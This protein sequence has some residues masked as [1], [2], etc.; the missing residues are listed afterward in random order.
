M[1]PCRRRDL[2]R[3]D[4]ARRGGRSHLWSSP[5][6]PVELVEPGRAA[7]GEPACRRRLEVLR[8]TRGA[9]RTRWRCGRRA[10]GAGAG[11]ARRRGPRRCRGRGAGGRPAASRV[12]RR[13]GRGADPRSASSRRGRGRR[14]GSR[15]D[16]AG[17][18][19]R[20]VQRAELV[21]IERLGQ[22]RPEREVLTLAASGDGRRAW[23][24]RVGGE[25]VGGRGAG[26]RAGCASV[27]AA[28]DDA[29]LTLGLAAARRGGC[30]AGRGAARRR[31][32]AARG[33][34]MVVGVL[35]RRRRRCAGARSRRR[36]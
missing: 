17:R 14:R 27:R 26:V 16:G 33:S 6:P 8:S 2:G 18:R 1:R 12:G 29:W 3:V 9:R 28:A 4:R 5:L 25:R 21:G 13:G 23:T 36:R 22:R 11:D 30:A 34:V 24:E 35:R 7:V 31:A 15:V 19:S 32:G 20:A 10:R